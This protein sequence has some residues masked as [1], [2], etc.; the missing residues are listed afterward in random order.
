MT[1][2]CRPDQR[3]TRLCGRSLSWV[4]ERGLR[5]Q[6]YPGDANA[7]STKSAATVLACDDNWDWIADHATAVA[8]PVDSA[9]VGSRG[10]PGCSA[11]VSQELLRA[12]S[13]STEVRLTCP[14]G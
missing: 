4:G 7:L 5:A 10:W 3:R 14:A 6:M 11:R 2:A 8:E 12:T 9:T 13:A 1:V